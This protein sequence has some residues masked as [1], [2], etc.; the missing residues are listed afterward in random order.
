MRMSMRQPR[1]K[2]RLH[3]WKMTT[4]MRKT[5]RMKMR[6]T[7]GV[8]RERQTVCSYGHPWWL[9]TPPPPPPL[10]RLKWSTS[11][12]LWMR[13]TTTVPELV[14]TTTAAKARWVWHG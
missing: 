3:Q 12:H 14:P 1:T 13:M 11:P 2:R 5:M 4:K 9:P 7:R 8:T 10:P 6:T